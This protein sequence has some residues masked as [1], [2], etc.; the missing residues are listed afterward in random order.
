AYAKRTVSID[1]TVFSRAVVSASVRL[2]RARR[3]SSDEDSG[4]AA[5]SKRALWPE[6]DRHCLERGPGKI[7]A[8][9]VADTEKFLRLNFGNADIA[10][11][12]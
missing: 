7:L 1:S 5:T 12:H 10:E 3:W 9:L 2:A 8:E 11:N 6:G 4:Y